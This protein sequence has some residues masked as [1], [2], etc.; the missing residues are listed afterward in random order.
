MTP[1]SVFQ[2]GRKINVFRYT[3]M[4]NITRSFSSSSY[5]NIT[6][7]F[8]GLISFNRLYS[9]LFTFPS[10]YCFSIGISMI[11]GLGEDYLLFHATFWS[12]ATWS[13][14]V[15]NSKYLGFHQY[16]FGHNPM[17]HPYYFNNKYANT[18]TI[19]IV[20]ADPLPFSFASTKGITFVCYSTY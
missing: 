8:Y 20:F 13:R 16:L 5:I 1:W 9:L 3:I 2:D 4:W 10:R 18:T 15:S 7:F 17:H 6:F 12:N 11:L 19:K 14:I